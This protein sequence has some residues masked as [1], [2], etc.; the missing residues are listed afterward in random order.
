VEK[1]PRHWM[2]YPKF[3]YLEKRTGFSIENPLRL[4]CKINEKYNFT[5][6][7]V[8]EEITL[9]ALIELMLDVRRA[10]HKII[11]ENENFPGQNKQT[12]KKPYR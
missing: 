8:I 1:S 11:N 2:P 10:N 6:C 7:D 4:A 5:V 3:E 12:K 9:R